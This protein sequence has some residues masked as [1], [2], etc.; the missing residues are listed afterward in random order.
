MGQWNN[1]R[2]S[3]RSLSLARENFATSSGFASLTIARLMALYWRFLSLGH[4]SE[5]FKQGWTCFKNG[6]YMLLPHGLWL[7]IIVGHLSRTLHCS[8]F[9][10]ICFRQLFFAWHSFTRW[11]W[12]LTF[13][14]LRRES[15][16]KCLINKHFRVQIYWNVDVINWNDIAGFWKTKIHRQSSNGDI[17]VVKPNQSFG[18]LTIVQSTCPGL[19]QEIINPQDKKIWDIERHIIVCLRNRMHGTWSYDVFKA[20]THQ[21]T[22]LALCPL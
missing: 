12:G 4:S 14:S 13:R 6:C 21:H 11:R 16:V 2:S 5:F 19:L 8:Y 3:S 17:L 15:L 22:V 18:S 20:C 10:F 9:F 7:S 1:V